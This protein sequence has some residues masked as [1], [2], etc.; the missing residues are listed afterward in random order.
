L[1]MT[2]LKIR[3]LIDSSFM[4]YDKKSKKSRPIEYKDIVLL[5]PTKKNNLTILEIFKTLD[6]PL[7]MKDAQNYFQATEIRTMI[8]LLQL[9]DNP[10][11][12]IPL[13]AVLRSPIVGLIEPELAS[14]RLA[15]RAHTYYDAVLA[16]QASN[17]DELA[18]KLEHFGKQLEHWRELARRSSI[19][20]LLW[21]IY[22]ETGYL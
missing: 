17:E 6:I 8:S 5:T 18:A 13:A 11:Q 19:T 1:F 21:D 3:Q 20:D 15:D 12:D 9:I 14:I 4:I 2:G 22:Y 10:Y 16:Y 7:E